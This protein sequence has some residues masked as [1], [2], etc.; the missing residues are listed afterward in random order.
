MTA[1]IRLDYVDPSKTITDQTLRPAHHFHRW[2]SDVTRRLG[3]PDDDAVELALIA[4]KEG[5]GLALALIAGTPTGYTQTP[6][7]PLSYT[8]LT[9]P[10]N[11][12][13]IN[14]AGHTRST[15][16][17]PLSAGSVAAAVTRDALYYVYYVDPS[18][19][20]GIVTYLSST[21][22]GVVAADAANRRLVGAVFIPARPRPSL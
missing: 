16:A 13:M 2:I 9:T 6:A 14:V 21:D 11:S 10:P 12:A 20:G 3:G 7:Q 22:P 17:S 8:L 5:F 19:N 1:Q 4:G 18:N 15:A